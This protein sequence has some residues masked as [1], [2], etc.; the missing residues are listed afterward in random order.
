[1]KLSLRTKRA[2]ELLADIDYLDQLEG[3]ARAW[4]EVYFRAVAN[5]ET[6]AI[7][8]LGGPDDTRIRQELYSE[9]RAQRRD[10]MYVGAQISLETL[11]TSGPGPGA[12]PHCCKP[13][14]KC[15][16]RKRHSRYS[17]SDYYP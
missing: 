1:M 9:D 15:A 16:P 5:L 10:V 2:R 14:C 6:D 13:N 11:L 17:Q 4:F 8:I 12:C 3:S 7:A